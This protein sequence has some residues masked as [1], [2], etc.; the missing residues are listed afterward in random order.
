MSSLWS[1]NQRGSTENVLHGM[2]LGKDHALIT[3]KR[4]GRMFKVVFPFDTFCVSVLWWFRCGIR[5]Y[6]RH[7]GCSFIATVLCSI[8]LHGVIE[9]H[10]RDVDDLNN[11]AGACYICNVSRRVQ[12]KEDLAFVPSNACSI[13]LSYLCLPLLTLSTCMVFVQPTMVHCLAT[14]SFQF[15]MSKK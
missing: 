1:A 11:L 6:G 3:G 8:Y 5:W 13:S 7:R 10:L 2:A 4:W 14:F 9:F 12:M 15:R